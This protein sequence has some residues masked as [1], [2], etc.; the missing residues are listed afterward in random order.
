MRIRTATVTACVLLAVAVGA[1]AALAKNTN[2]DR[3]TAA[4]SQSQDGRITSH[5]RFSFLR[6]RLQTV[7]PKSEADAELCGSY[8]HARAAIGAV[9]RSGWRQ[10]SWATIRVRDAK[11][12]HYY[13]VWVRLDG[14][15]PLTGKASTA[16]A[17]S[18]AVHGLI[19]VT[20]ASALLGEYAKYGDDG[21]G[22]TGEINGFTT[23]S[24][25]NGTLRVR[26]DFGLL[27]GAYPFHRVNRSF[28]A[29]PIVDGSGDEQRV[30]S[31]VSHCGTPGNGHGLVSK[32]SSDPA[33]GWFDLIAPSRQ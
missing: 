6:S 18:S 13:T 24:R 12:N 11:P 26:L 15:S 33:Q 32:T 28:G 21:T 29:V 1:P 22:G 5:G 19:P 16:L 9:Q 3:S 14:S 20:P 30:I 25:G 31:I 2:G 4:S 17:P 8:P 10:R 23:N 7:F 27:G